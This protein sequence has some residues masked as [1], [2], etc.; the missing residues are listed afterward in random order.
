MKSEKGSLL[1]RWG[2]D[3]KNNCKSHYNLVGQ[4]SAGNMYKI[5]A[6]CE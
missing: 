5:T 3:A 2:N 6:T 1:V 4:P